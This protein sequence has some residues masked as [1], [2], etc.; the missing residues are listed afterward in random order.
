MHDPYHHRRPSPLAAA[1]RQVGLLLAI[2]LLAGGAIWL[3]NWIG[4]SASRS[5]G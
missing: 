3:F 1:L 5:G 2:A 4:A